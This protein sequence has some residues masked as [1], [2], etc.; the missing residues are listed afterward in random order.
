MDNIKTFYETDGHDYK[1]RRWKQYPSSKFDFEKTRKSILTFLEGKK[2]NNV[3]EVGCGP[4]TWTGFVKEHTNNLLAVDI[5]ETMIAE[6]KKE[7]Q[8][9]EVKFLNTDIMNYNTDEKFDLIF[10]IRAFEY[11][12]DKKGF[13]NKCEKMLNENG[14]VF[15]ITKTKA[16][17]WYG[18]TKIRKL[19]KSILPILFYYENNEATN[20]HFKNLDN[21]KQERLT[22]TE[23]EKILRSSHFEDIKIRPVIVRPPIFMRGKS[24]IPL[25]PPIFEKLILAVLHP[26]DN[27]LS[28][29]SIFT[30][31]AESYSINGKKK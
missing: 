19:L 3:L 16:S 21:F 2:F 10:S 7:I 4:G 26:I 6:A 20:A 30:I 5:S 22:T 18:R 12:P 29:F 15:I 9:P 23:F 25:V 17:Y 1:F 24:E 11:F 28:K 27:V 31:F 14:Q 13:I 8:N